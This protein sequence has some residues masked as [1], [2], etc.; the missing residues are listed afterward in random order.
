MAAVWRDPA[1]HIS[2][3][4]S[5]AF[6]TWADFHRFVQENASIPEFGEDRAM[7]QILSADF[8]SRLTAATDHDWLLLG[9]LGLPARVPAAAWPPDFTPATDTAIDPAYLMPRNAFDL[10]LCAL[11]IND[12]DP[13]EAARLYGSLVETAVRQVAAASEQ[14][15]TAHGL[16]LGGLVRY[17]A[18]DLTVHPNGQVMGIV[19]A[20]PIDPGFGPA[21]TIGVD[22]P[23]GIEIDI[24]PPSKVRLTVPPEPCRR[25]VVGLDVPGMAAYE[26]ALYP[27]VNQLADKMALLAGPPVTL[28]AAPDG[29][30]HRYKDLF[31]SYFIV[32]TCPI[33]ADQMR[34]AIESNWNLD[35]LQ[36]NRLP[37]PYHVFGSGPGEPNIPW[38]AGC[39]RLRGTSA[40]LQRYPDFTEMN[41]MVGSF[42]DGLASAPPGAVW[43]AERGWTAGPTPPD[44]ETAEAIGL[45]RGE[46]KDRSTSGPTSSQ[47]GVSGAGPA[48]HLPGRSPDRSSGGEL[49]R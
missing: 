25:P 3:D 35:R 44:P 14:P 27:T 9:S 5:A 17:S 26:P 10:D 32:K 4:F 39:D 15:G 23:I 21:Q 43:S 45:L 2:S 11:D 6:P 7:H 22:D 29:L 37:V 38:R 16:G 19:T 34:T 36:L 24:K 12:P 33:D 13:D 20:Q 42:V 8:A 49:D 40:Q 48:K 31:D 41:R 30:W 47:P 46:Q 18:A 1:P 28:R